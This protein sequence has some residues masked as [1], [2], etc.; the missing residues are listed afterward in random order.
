MAKIVIKNVNRRVLTS[1]GESREYFLGQMSS[2]DARDLTFVPVIAEEATV[3]RRRTYLNESNNGYQRP[4]VARRMEAFAHYLATYPLA[5]TPAVVL[6]GRGKWE[7]SEKDQT[8]NVLAPAAIIDGQHRL[9]GFV[10]DYESNENERMIDFVLINFESVNE[11]ERIFVDINSTAKSVASG[12]V[13]VIGRSADVQVAELL[14]NHPDSLFKGK[15]Y[16]AQGRPETLFNINSV[17]KEIG[18]TFSHG[19][20]QNIA[21]DI[22]MKY[23]IA[24][25]YWGEIS[26]AFPN[27][28][29]DI[30]LPRNS[31]TYKLL[32]LTG[33]ITWSKAASE[34]LV[35]AYD[36]ESKTINWDVVRRMI[37][38]LAEPG[39]IDW[40]KDGKYQ[41]ATGNRGAQLI[42][43][44][45]Q[46]LLQGRPGH[47][48]TQDYE[49]HELVQD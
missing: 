39:A 36:Q 33:F 30:G 8:L 23:E 9:G 10:C 22:D 21:N 3:R 16:I 7:Y 47:E 6:S 40:A 2:K 29:A 43:R 25:A 1:N 17:M 31:R 34:I 18:T 37:N 11:E 32:E 12:I 44:D 5:Y 19:A 41:N 28:W 46:Q 20:F 4:G 27:E 48:L 38:L 35:P 14:N 26:D 42:H 45:I 24:L 49:D 15:F 13:A